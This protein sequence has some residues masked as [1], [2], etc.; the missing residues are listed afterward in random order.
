MNARC[1]RRLLALTAIVASGCS[2]ALPDGMAQDSAVGTAETAEVVE[3][4]PV[5]GD[6]PADPPGAV[7]QASGE[8]A[9]CVRE[10]E[11]TMFSSS[12]PLYS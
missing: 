4:R 2:R 1:V 7:D 12:F 11:R 6:M 3:T 9:T 10:G 8:V 5:V